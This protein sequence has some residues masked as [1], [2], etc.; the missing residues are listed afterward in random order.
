METNMEYRDMLWLVLAP[1]SWIEAEERAVVEAYKEAMRWVSER[2][3][4]SP[5]QSPVVPYFP[6]ERE[7]GAPFLY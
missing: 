1:H 5:R 7:S 2:T 4:R 3:A 6:Q